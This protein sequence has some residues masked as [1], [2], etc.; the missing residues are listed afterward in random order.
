MSA[1]APAG[2]PS[3]P[4]SPGPFLGPLLLALMAC[5]LLQ[6]FSPGR[7]AELGTQV[8]VL[9]T[10]LLG[11]T[12]LRLREFYLLGI[13]LVLLALALYRL[14]DA[15]ET[16]ERGLERASFL[17]AF[18]LLMGLLREGGITSPAVRDCGTYITRQPPQRRFLAVFMGS[19]FFS[20][21]INL[22]ALSL[23]APIILRGVRGDKST[24]E[25]LD[26]IGRV[27]ERRQL[28]ALLRGFAWFLVW[29]P[30][31]VTQAIL[32]TLI[33]GIETG[34]LL[35]TGLAVAFVMLLVSWLE[36]MLRWWPL[37]RRL[38]NSGQ[39]PETGGQAFPGPAFF[40]LGCIS[41]LLLGLTLA[42]STLGSV[43]LVNGVMLA[44]PL[45]LMVWVFAQQG[46]H[47]ATAKLRGSLVRLGAI[48]TGNLPS[49][50]REAVS[51]GAAG[52]IGTLAARLIPADQVASALSV[53]Q[54]PGWL[55]LFGLSAFVWLG[56]QIALSPI[57]TAVFLGS[58]VADLG[59]IPVSPTL[60]ALAI[61]AGT[62]ICT[63]GAPF[64]SGTL[65]LARASGH[66]G[67]E[68]AWK[69]NLP[70][71]LVA[72]AVLALIYAGLTAF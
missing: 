2:D 8:L 28:S 19:H 40:R 39:M 10:P 25:A 3:A 65:M 26:E 18:I 38:R 42:L 21:L 14:P 45:V 55:F 17:A 60:A 52:F 6:L 5:E 53:E 37:R 71:T 58:L 69:W 22:G 20:V 27:R 51:L 46:G 29:A 24:G 59:I 35:V 61:A 7:F 33:P 30:T 66:S 41:A 11:F 9:A 68:L 63:T 70:Y 48:T 31:A 16:I 1:P 36:D 47:S 49:F 72:M 12:R 15:A 32:P 44:A 34:R 43:S 23:L 50:V 57:T 56:G 62:A 67:I 54:M 13:A 64:A 4:T